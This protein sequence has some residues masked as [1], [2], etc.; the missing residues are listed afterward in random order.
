ME[1]FKGFLNKNKKEE[2][3]PKE[4]YDSDKKKIVSV[5]Q[6]DMFDTNLSEEERQKIVKNREDREDMWK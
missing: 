6:E 1:L 5:G 2:I 3:K 4:T